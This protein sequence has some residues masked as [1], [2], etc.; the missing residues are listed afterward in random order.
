MKPRNAL[1]ES[2]FTNLGWDGFHP[3]LTRGGWLLEL[4]DVGDQVLEGDH[5]GR[6]A[7]QINAILII[8]WLSIPSPPRTLSRFN[9]IADHYGVFA[10]G[11]VREIF[12]F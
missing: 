12:E 10:P 9:F 3:R 2:S 7:L 1:I 8:E 5:L 4:F 11:N 6:S